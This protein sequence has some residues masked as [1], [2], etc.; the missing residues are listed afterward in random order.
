MKKPYCNMPFEAVVHY[1]ARRVII[2]YIFFYYIKVKRKFRCF[3][4][5]LLTEEITR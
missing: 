1:D 5:N 2:P 4:E 3:S